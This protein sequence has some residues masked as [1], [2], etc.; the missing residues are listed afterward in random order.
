MHPGA[1]LPGTLPHCRLLAPYPLSRSQ[2]CSSFPRPT[3]LGCCTVGVSC[4]HRPHNQPRTVPTHPNHPSCHSLEQQHFVCGECIKQS[5][6]FRGFAK[7]KKS[8]IKLYRAHTTHPLTLSKL[9][10]GNPSLT[11]TE[12]SII[13]TNNFQQCMHK[14]NAH[15]IL[16]Q[17]VSTGIGLFWDDF[18][19]FF[20]NNNNNNNFI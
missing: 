19:I 2:R 10:F 3:G 7:F 16:L 9:F 6:Q 11:G 8:K 4:V 17:N 20:Y 5:S 14:Q 15:G 1:H 13:T 18:P 12:H